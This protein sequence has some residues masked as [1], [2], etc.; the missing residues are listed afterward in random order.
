MPAKLTPISVPLRL[1]SNDG[2]RAGG[3]D[4]LQQGRHFLRFGGGVGVRHDLDRVDYALQVGGELGFQV[5][6]QHG[7]S[8]LISRL[9]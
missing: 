3:H 7:Y 9:R 2:L 6:V 4:V 5:C 1:M 8:F